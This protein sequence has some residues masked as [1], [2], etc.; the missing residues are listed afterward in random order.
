MRFELSCLGGGEP[1][2]GVV[3]ELSEAVGGVCSVKREVSVEGGAGMSRA[4]RM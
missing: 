3:S 1:E 2:Y 4:N